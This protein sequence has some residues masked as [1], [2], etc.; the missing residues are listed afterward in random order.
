LIVR[1]RRQNNN[2]TKR[3]WI[4]ELRFRFNN[5]NSKTMVNSRTHIQIQFLF[6]L[7]HANLNSYSNAWIYACLKKCLN[8]YYQM[9]VN[10]HLLF[11]F[12]IILFSVFII[13]FLAIQFHFCFFLFYFLKE[14]ILS[15]S[16]ILSL[17][18]INVI[19]TN[20]VPSLHFYVGYNNI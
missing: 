8:L 18:C 20:W 11:M 10:S 4:H 9:T 3:R 6:L 16:S 1:I 19:M 7:L 14:H 13:L 17:Y 15:S 5:N 12:L 2:N